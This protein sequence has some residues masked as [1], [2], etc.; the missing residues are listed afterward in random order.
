[1]DVE[2]CG[3]SLLPCLTLK[4]AIMKK[5]LTDHIIIHGSYARKTAVFHESHITINKTIKVIGKYGYPV[6]VAQNSSLLTVVSPGHQRIHITFI[7]LNFDGGAHNSGTD[8]KV[9]FIFIEDSSLHLANCSFLSVARPLAL[10]CYGNCNYTIVH[11]R[12]ISPVTAIIV[13]GGRK[14]FTNISQTY[15]IGWQGKS[16][17]ALGYV[18][19]SIPIVVTKSLNISIS[20]CSFSSFKTAVLLYTA[21]RV[22][23]ISI[24][25]S[26]FENNINFGRSSYGHI[27]SSIA[28]K[29]YH[30]TLHNRYLSF[31]AISC[32]F[33]NNRGNQ[34][35]GISLNITQRQFQGTIIN[36][37]FK[38]NVARVTG[39]AV[40]FHT[41]IAGKLMFKIRNCRFENNIVGEAYLRMMDTFHSLT[42]GSGGALSFVAAKMINGL[43]Y[44]DVVSVSSCTFIRNSAAIEGGSIYSFLVHL[45]LYNLTF[46]TPTR[47]PLFMADGTVLKLTGFTILSKI[48]IEVDDD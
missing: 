2:I 5:A 43:E 10:K 32:I 19:P 34:G 26:K 42:F 14:T 41:E 30:G 7:N 20:Y 6:I 9:F 46:I 11:S 8:E 23:G 48:R 27:S 13:Q 45:M 1:M 16:Q 38:D 37:T 21:A 39:G 47:Y 31:E 25:Y 22:C 29:D 4:Y 18:H 15:F 35:P 3:S 24:R 12:I 40:S 17:V 36:C 33:L 28:V 44:A